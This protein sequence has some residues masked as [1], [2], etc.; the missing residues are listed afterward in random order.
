V[1]AVRAIRLALL[2]IALAAGSG[3]SKH[4]LPPN[5]PPTTGT[6]QGTVLLTGTRTDTTG[7][8]VDSF[9]VAD[10][11]GILVYLVSNGLPADSTA[12]SSGSYRFQNVRPDTYQVMV[13]PIP[14]V[15]RQ[16]TVIQELGTTVATPIVVCDLG[17]L[18][19]IPNPSGGVAHIYF[20]LPAYEGLILNVRALDGRVLRTLLSAELLPGGHAVNWDGLDGDGIPVNPGTYYLA[21]ESAGDN[22][23]AVVRRVPLPAGPG[24]IGGTEPAR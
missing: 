8:V 20:D 19:V 9:S 2:L 7:A 3:C 4:H 23:L 13:R 17:L 21:F 14:A 24:T 15:E 5:A 18:T 16:V 10:G 22:R 6:L 1:R 12:T 11:T